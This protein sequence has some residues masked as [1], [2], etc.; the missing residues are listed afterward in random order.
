MG[1]LSE[2]IQPAIDSCWKKVDEICDILF[3]LS[4]KDRVV[5]Y[6]NKRRDRYEREY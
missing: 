5:V 3:G 1:T 2:R 4:E 6:E